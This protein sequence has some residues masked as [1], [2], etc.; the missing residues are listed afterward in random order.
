MFECL[1]CGNLH[2][3]DQC[4][5]EHA[6]PQSLGGD[7]APERFK[8]RNVGRKCN[9]DLGQFVDASFTKSFF[10]S[11]SLAM[12]A[13]KLYE[14]IDNFPLP[15][16]C[17]GQVDVQGIRIPDGYVSEFW[18][19]PS[20]ETLVWLRPHDERVYWYAGGNPLDRK[21]PSTLYWFPTS[22]DPTRLK[23]GFQSLNAAFKSRKK[24]RRVL[25]V[26]CHGFPGNGYPQ[27]FDMPSEL[28]IAN[29]SSIR[30]Q[31]GEIRGKFSF[32]CDFDYRFVAK[33]SLGVGFSL[34]GEQFLSTE[35]AAEFRKACWPEKHS[36]IEMYGTPSLGVRNSSH[37]E[38][39]GYSGAVV[40]TVMPAGHDY[41]LSLSVDEGRPFTVALAP[42]SLKSSLIDPFMGYCLLLFPSLRLSLETT[43]IELIAHRR[44]SSKNRFLA[45]ID[46]RMERSRFFWSMLAPLREKQ[47][48]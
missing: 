30:D 38:F 14:G 1:Y 11:S 9:N 34:L 3:T 26:P 21:M 47:L 20:G 2:P 5:E 46:E 7:C 48:E 25:G 13:R 40:I 33:L 4:T 18:V 43:L 23:I 35:H 16:I 15:L 12:A 39:I 28:D 29:I 19:G 27:G 31:M 17:L 22:D 45:A 37:L 24:T 10:V 6:I 42:S 8:L 36:Q 32:N 41:A 44:G